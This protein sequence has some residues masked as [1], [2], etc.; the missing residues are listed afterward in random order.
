MHFTLG[1]GDFDLKQWPEATQAFMKAA[2]L[3][4]KNSTAAYNVAVSNLNARFYTDAI[5]WYRE[6]LRRNPNRRTAQKS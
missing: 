4:P 1:T 6:A 2:E 3:D 5:T